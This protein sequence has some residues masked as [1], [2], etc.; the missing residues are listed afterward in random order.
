[1]R[2]TYFGFWIAYWGLI[3]GVGVP[4][5]A[6]DESLSRKEKQLVRGISDQVDRAAKLFTAR[7]FEDCRA[8]YLEAKSLIE[9]V[10]EDSPPALLAELAPL[11]AKLV[12][13]QELLGQNGQTVEPPRPLPKNKESP[14]SFA[15]EIAPLLVAKCGGCHVTNM[16]G[17]FGMATHAAL[18][19]SG[20]VV[21]GD[22][23]ESRLIQL[24]DNGE[25]PKGG[26]KVEPAELELLRKWIREGAKNDADE[27]ANLRTLGPMAANTP[28]N[29]TPVLT[30]ATGKETVSFTRD[31]APLLLDNCTGCH[32]DA[33]RPRANLN[34]TTF[35]SLLRG[36]D[37][38]PIVKPGNSADS[39]L[40][41]KLLGTADGN[42][43][44]QGKPPL[45]KAALD[46]VSQWIDEGATFDAAEATLPIRTLYQRSRAARLSHLELAKERLTLAEKTWNT[47][48]SGH[49]HQTVSTAEIQLLAKGRPEAVQAQAAQI[50]AVV[51][52]LKR[53]LK[54]PEDQPLLRGKISVMIVDERYDFDEYGTMILG[55]ALPPSSKSYWQFNQVDAH[56]V[57]LLAAND[58][59]SNFDVELGRNLAAVYYDSLAEDVPRWFADGMGYSAAAKI[60]SRSDEAASWEARALETVRRMNQP[61][62]FIA[63]RLPEDQAGL[64]GYYF[65][66]QLRT[67]G[68]AFNK[69]LGGLTKGQLFEDSFAKAFGLPPN[70][71]LQGGSERKSGNRR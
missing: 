13:A 21:A 23:V 2:P 29:P 38:G 1:M 66:A 20:H 47:F 4:I 42:R 24:I 60:F 65:L 14:T 15:N 46:L 26:G 58:D 3:C 45:A 56:V 16:R 44:P 36:G 62:D 11:H 41:K 64:A 37:N 30:R 32:L 25:M 35:E 53:A 59:G 68:G 12:K 51:A 61:D 57:L 19:R 34:L 6:Q 71:F 8:A 39:L 40:I 33:Q 43:M 69:L 7:K 10:T 31:I 17:Q 70:E 27:N 63:G 9:T 49:Q 28:A 54:Q 48:N 67:N 5:N 22:P 18:M 52:E 50:D 55:H